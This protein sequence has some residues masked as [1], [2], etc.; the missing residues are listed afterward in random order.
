MGFIG[1]SIFVLAGAV[2]FAGGMIHDAG[3]GI[4]NAI[5]SRQ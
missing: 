2:I 5:K 4:S 3:V 1:F